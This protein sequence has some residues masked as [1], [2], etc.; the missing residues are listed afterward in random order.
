[1]SAI[2]LAFPGKAAPG[3]PD[4]DKEL[5]AIQ[6]GFNSLL[7]EPQQ[8]NPASP[9]GA[10]PAMGPYNMP[11]FYLPTGEVHTAG[12]YID[13]MRAH[14]KLTVNAI[15]LRC[16]A[17]GLAVYVAGMIRIGADFNAKPGARLLAYEFDA[18]EPSVHT[19]VTDADGL[20]KKLQGVLRETYNRLAAKY[21]LI[22]L[23]KHHLVLKSSSPVI[24][25]IQLIQ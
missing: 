24:P 18:K 16:D 20:H 23:R 25:D 7:S 13:P 21:N 17:L 10:G 5:E 9:G 14:R 6:V 8:K 4:V 19:F 2:V 1:M 12:Q 3:I 22:G 11:I 15:E